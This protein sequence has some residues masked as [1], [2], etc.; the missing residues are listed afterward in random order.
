MQALVKVEVH[1]NRKLSACMQVTIPR[2]VKMLQKI[3]VSMFQAGGSFKLCIWFRITF[4]V[5]MQVFN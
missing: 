1:A 4:Q 2:Y 5:A 3:E